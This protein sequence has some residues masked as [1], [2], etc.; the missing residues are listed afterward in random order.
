MYSP[1]KAEEG[2]IRCRSRSIQYCYLQEDSSQTNGHS[3]GS[4]AS[5]R[6]HLNREQPQ[7]KPPQCKCKCKKGEAAGTAAQGSKSHGAK[8]QHLVLMSP[9]LKLAVEGVHYIAD[10]LR[11]EDADFSVSIPAEPALLQKVKNDLLRELHQALSCA[12]CVHADA[13]SAIPLLWVLA[14]V[15]TAGDVL[16]VLA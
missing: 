8:E 11:A 16:G 4:P 7:H 6:C 5:Q 14:T 9:A 10:H 3:S 15:G 13:G 1:N 12:D 2:T